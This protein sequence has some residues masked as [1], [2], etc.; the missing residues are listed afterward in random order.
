M[1]FRPFYT[2][3][4]NSILKM[5][6]AVNRMDLIFQEIAVI[7]ALLGSRDVLQEPYRLVA[8]W[9]ALPSM[10]TIEQCTAPERR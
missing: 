9:T 6:A 8:Y 3:P 4:L 1:V 5:N 7:Y 10:T 2:A